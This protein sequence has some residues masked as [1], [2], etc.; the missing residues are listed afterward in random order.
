MTPLAELAAMDR[1]GLATLWSDLLGGDV[2]PKMSQ[3]MQRR[4][5]AFEL[6]ARSEG[7]LSAALV[8]RL[9][10]IAQGEERKPSQV[11]A[12]GARLLRVW[13]GTTQVVDVLPDGF[14]WN[15]ARHGSLSAIARAITGAR[16]SGPRFFGLVSAADGAGGKAAKRK[17]GKE[18]RLTPSNSMRERAA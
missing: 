9:T 6:Q 8:A 16:W 5:L 11:L 4:F 3:Q 13:N 15:G 17:A 1:T 2:P 12:S 14:L 7:G 18:K 10:R